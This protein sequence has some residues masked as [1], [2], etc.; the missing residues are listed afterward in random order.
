VVQVQLW[1]ST[2]LHAGGCIGGIILH[3][4]WVSSRGLLPLLGSTRAAAVAEK[5]PFLWQL[6]HSMS[7]LGELLFFPLLWDSDDLKAEFFLA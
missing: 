7:F 6:K 2:I 1:T 4:S 3:L 5:C